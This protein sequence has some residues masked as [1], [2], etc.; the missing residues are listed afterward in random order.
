MYGRENAQWG[1]LQYIEV[2]VPWDCLICLLVIISPQL[3]NERR[4]FFSIW[5][6][7]RRYLELNK[8]NDICERMKTYPLLPTTSQQGAWATTTAT[9]TR[10]A[11]KAIGSGLLHMSLVDRADLV[12]GN[13]FA[14]GSYGN[15]HPGFRD[16]KADNPVDEFWREIWEISKH[17]EKQKL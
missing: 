13:N 5:S 4:T 8:S 6:G 2:N 10:T 17:G 9:A 14:L 7:Y 16:D 3:K 1:V 12:C 15:F 11:I